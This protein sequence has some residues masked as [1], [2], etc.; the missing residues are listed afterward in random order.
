MGIKRVPTYRDFRS[1]K[2]ILHNAFVSGKMP[3]R[4]FIWI[5]GNLHL[6]DNNLMPKQSEK[7]FDKLY[8]VHPLLDHLSEMFFKVFKPGQK[9]SIDKRKKMKCGD[10][11]WSVSSDDIACIKWKDKRIV[12]SLTTLDE[13][14]KSC[15]N[16][17]KEK[18]GKKL[19]QHAPES[20]YGLQ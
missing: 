13:A 14:T 6:N 15:E 3:M 11:D 16:E 20:S 5:L 8:K 1:T 4:K 9:Q 2:E 19:K 17:R 10:F 7:N 18:D 12:H